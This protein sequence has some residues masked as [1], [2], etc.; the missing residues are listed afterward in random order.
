MVKKL[1][2]QDG[3]H[4]MSGD[5]DLHVTSRNEIIAY[6]RMN[7]APLAKYGD[8]EQA[9]SAVKSASAYQGDEYQF[10]PDKSQLKPH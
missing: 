10:P 4:S 3:T 9:A 1:I 2:S 6:G 5:A 7:V 8:T